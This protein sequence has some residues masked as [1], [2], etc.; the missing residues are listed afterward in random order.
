MAFKMKGSA[1][2]RG[3]VATKKT[4]AYQVIGDAIHKHPGYKGGHDPLLEH[5]PPLHMKSP[6]KQYEDVEGYTF[7]DEEL[8]SD[9]RGVKTYRRKGTK[10]GTVST[11]K[12]YQQRWAEMS[13]EERAAR[14]GN[15]ADW[16][17][18]ADEWR[19]GQAG[20]ELTQTRTE[21]EPTLLPF[22]NPQLLTSD[23]DYTPGLAEYKPPKKKRTT[24]K[25]KRKRVGER[26][27]DF[28]GNIGDN[29]KR[30][31]QKRRGGVGRRRKRGRKGC[32]NQGWLRRQ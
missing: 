21:E 12:T 10:P 6:V 25:R 24:T 22:L 7:G 3:D 27:G 1:F 28:F 23:I 13:D 8:V 5:K 11:G 9:E 31:R 29:I 14:G 17:K 19:K 15:Y 18:R 26:I 32:V 16:S 20:D 30:A 2:K 4:M